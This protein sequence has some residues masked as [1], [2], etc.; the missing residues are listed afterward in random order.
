MTAMYMRYSY[1]DLEMIDLDPY[2][3]EVLQQYKSKNR[4]EVSPCVFS[5]AESVDYNINTYHK[6]QCV[7]ISSE[8][9]AGFAWK[10]QTCQDAKD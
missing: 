2:T 9:G 10:F 8:S 6:I 5:I 1:I 7:V 3:D 4:L